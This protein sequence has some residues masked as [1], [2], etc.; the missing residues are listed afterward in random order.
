M[1]V[2]WLLLPLVF[3]LFQL[4]FAG[5]VCR[6]N[7]DGLSGRLELLRCKGLERTTYKVVLKKGG[8]RKVFKYENPNPVDYLPFAVPPTWSGEVEFFLYKGNRLIGKAVLG[9]V[10]EAG[11]RSLAPG[12][13][14]ARVM[15]LTGLERE[16]KKPPYGTDRQYSLVRKILS[17]YTPVRYYEKRAIFPLPFFKYVSSPFGVSRVIMGK[18]ESLH[19]GV[20]LAAPEGTPVLAALSGRVVFA[21][22]LTLT[23]NTV[24]IDHGWGLM[25]LYAHLSKISVR[26]GWFV[27]RGTVV[28]KVGS[29]GFSTG[30]HLHFGVYL[31]DTPVDPVDFLKK[32]LRP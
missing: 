25:T 12:T 31:N 17:T 2:G 8:Y 27:R 16:G 14:R 11:G 32:E 7:F 18:R 19:R 30:P 26:K 13:L 20:D 22:Y 10:R 28:G 3:L 6:L 21:D 29:T 24:I 5:A 23:G 9:V 15:W 4:S 1:G